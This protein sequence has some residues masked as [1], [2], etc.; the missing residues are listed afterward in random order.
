MLAYSAQDLILEPFAGMYSDL[1]PANRPSSPAFSTPVFLRAC[2]SSASLGS[3]SVRGGGLEELEH[4]AGV[5]PPALALIGLVD[6]RHNRT[7]WPTLAKCLRAR[8]LQWCVRGRSYRI[9]DGSWRKKGGRRRKACGWAFGALRRVIAFGL[10]GFMGT[11]A[12][13]I[14]RALSAS[15]VTAYAVA[16]FLSHCFFWPPRPVSAGIDERKGKSVNR[17]VAANQNSRGSSGQ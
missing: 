8:L 5:S 17:S 11:V 9:D 1:R 16:F 14:V 13:D 2:Y 4:T 3:R 12:V 7:T 15:A 10:G 6:R